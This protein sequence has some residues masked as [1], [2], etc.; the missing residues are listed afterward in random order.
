MP[1]DS[2]L[3]CNSIWLHLI[4]VYRNQR[5]NYRHPPPHQGL[6]P[7]HAHAKRK[8]IPK[9]SA[10]SARSGGPANQCTAGR[11][12][13]R[14]L[15]RTGTPATR[16]PGPRQP[17]PPSLEV[18]QRPRPRCQASTSSGS[19]ATPAS[20]SINIPANPTSPPAEPT[21]APTSAPSQKTS[22]PTERTHQRSSRSG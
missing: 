20:S 2:W 15:P 1:P 6:H 16:Q 11:L 4:T 7:I 3:P 12:A 14:R 9:P 5:T 10:P 18:G 13:G 22:P 21:Q 8:Q 19:S 17:E